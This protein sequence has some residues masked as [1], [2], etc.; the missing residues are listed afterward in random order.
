MAVC[1]LREEF[2][3]VYSIVTDYRLVSPWWNSYRPSW[4]TALLMMMSRQCQPLYSGD[5][6]LLIVGAGL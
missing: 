3:P 5:T 4:L 2:H 1:E 6:K